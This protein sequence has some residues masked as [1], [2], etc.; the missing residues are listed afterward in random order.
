[1]IDCFVD[2]FHKLFSTSNPVFGGV[3][4]SMQRV[5]TDEMN[6]KLLKNVSPE[7]VKEAVFQMGPWK[8]PGPDGYPAMFY[9][10]YW[11]IVGEKVINAVQHF[12]I[13]G[14]MDPK[15]NVTHIVL[16]PKSSNPKKV[17][18]FRPISLCNVLYKVISRI[19]VNRLKGLMPMLISENQ[20]AFIK[21]RMITDN[22]L[23]AYETVHAMKHRQGAK[24][25]IAVKLDMSKA[26]D[27][28]EWSFIEAVLE[29]M[30]FAGG[31]IRL[32]MQCISTPSYSI[33]LNGE[34]KDRIIPSRG[35]R[36]GDPL[37]PYLFII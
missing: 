26:Y 14:C 21:G 24:G 11:G 36:Q 28:I 31:W 33:L 35:I 5:V 2:Y 20:S 7:E 9:Q 18:D 16:V 19:I 25:A 37:S 17:S 13:S 1:M 32:I 6:S 12:F 10:A 34:A 3:I 29:K 30:G 15:I 27:R 4:E 8:A 22:I 23:L